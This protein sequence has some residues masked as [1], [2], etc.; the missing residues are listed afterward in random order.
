MTAT[1]T[2]TTEEIAK[3]YE[4]LGPIRP[5]LLDDSLSEVMVNGYNQVFVERSGKI[6]M[7]DVHFDD[8]DHLLRVIDFIFGAVG[9]RI[10][11]RTP[12]ADA[13]LWEGSRVHAPISPLAPPRPILTLPTSTPH[14]PPP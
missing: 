12:M 8:N 7:T 1:T 6:L 10:D 14:P 13:R 5:L 2:R 3:Y 9:R 4:A 11:F